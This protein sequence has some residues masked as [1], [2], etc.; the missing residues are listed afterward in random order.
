[1]SMMHCKAVH[2]YNAIY[3]ITSYEHTQYINI[4]CMYIHFINTD[5]YINKQT[6]SPRALL[7]S[8][9]L[10]IKVEN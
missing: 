9:D 8:T 7:L 2:K 1:M 6:I 3:L 10:K 5:E 4:P